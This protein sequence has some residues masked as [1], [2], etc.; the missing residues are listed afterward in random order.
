MLAGRFPARARAPGDQLTEVDLRLA[1]LE[2]AF[3]ALRASDGAVVG[4]GGISML[5]RWS[6]CRRSIESPTTTAFRWVA[7]TCGRLAD[8]AKVHLLEQAP[9][10]S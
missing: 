10:R 6:V 4:G 3:L 7:Q 8:Y 5:A 9:V 1:G 2:V